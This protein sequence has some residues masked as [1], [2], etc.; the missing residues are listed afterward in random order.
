MADVGARTLVHSVQFNG[1]QE[2]VW[3]APMPF[4]LRCPRN[5]QANS[6]FGLAFVPHSH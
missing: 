1:K 2:G 6:P 3:V 4:G 5:G